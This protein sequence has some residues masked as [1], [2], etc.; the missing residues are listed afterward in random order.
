MEYNSFSS[1]KYKGLCVRDV[2]VGNWSESWCLSIRELCQYVF[3]DSWLHQFKNPHVLQAIIIGACSDVKIK[4]FFSGCELTKEELKSTSKVCMRSFVFGGK[5]LEFRFSLVNRIRTFLL[6]M[7]RCT[8][9]SICGSSTKALAASFPL[10][11]R[12]WLREDVNVTCWTETGKQRTGTSDHLPF[13][14]VNRFLTSLWFKF[15]WVSC[16]LMHTLVVFAYLIR[17]NVKVSSFLWIFSEKNFPKGP[18]E[19]SWGGVMR[20]IMCKLCRLPKKC[21]TYK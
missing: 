11:A 13:S 12:S 15:R 18:L 7:K 5:F 16:N 4:S 21:I 10:S 14:L 2:S 6:V 8:S 9:L 20:G 17:S 19:S 1:V 3:F